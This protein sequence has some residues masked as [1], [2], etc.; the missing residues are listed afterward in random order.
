MTPILEVIGLC[1]SYGG[2][3]VLDG[4]DLSVAEGE[5]FTLL[6]PSGSG[7]TTVLRLIAGFESSDSGDIRIRSASVVGVPPGKRRVGMVFQNYSLFP[8]MT[9]AENVEIGLRARR[10]PAS[11]RSE[12]VLDLLDAI[13]LRAEARRLPSELSG[14]ERQRVAVARA[15]AVE[16]SVLLMDEP[17]SALD[18]RVRET[19]RGEVRELQKRLG[20]T[21]LYV[22]HDQ[23]E[24]LGSSDRIC[25][26]SHRGIEQVGTPTEIYRTP[27][28]AFVADFI[29]KMNTFRCH[30]VGPTSGMVA[31][32][33]SRFS[34][35]EARG[36]P[37]GEGLVLRLRPEDLCLATDVLSADTGIQGTI[38]TV[39]F[40]GSIAHVAVETSQASPAVAQVPSRDAEQYRVGTRVL[41]G[42][43][44][45]AG[46]VL[47]SGTHSRRRIVSSAQSMTIQPR[48]GAAGPLAPDMQPG[49]VSRDE[50]G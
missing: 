28:S 6:G 39:I 41:I 7:K 43:R 46:H 30:V 13:G 32:G 26:L 21:V 44:P 11:E 31:C 45:G 17:F 16:P 14:G 35:Q 50:N 2:R 33:A 47:S 48:G 5:F 15:L 36:M 34:L 8:N 1:K 12:R 29:G 40:L 23:E 18:V 24:A 9:A 10:V 20:T 27:E 37:L 3:P 42:W 49:V 19:V 4:L 22:T 25:V 38:T